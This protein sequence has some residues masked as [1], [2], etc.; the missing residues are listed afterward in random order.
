M[1][2]KEL[3]QE[4]VLRTKLQAEVETEHQ[5]ALKD[6]KA[7][8]NKC[9]E[10][11]EADIKELKK[12]HEKQCEELGREILKQ[13]LEADRLFNELQTNGIQ[14]PRKALFKD[15]DV[16]NS[17]AIGKIINLI[18]TCVIVLLAVGVTR[19]HQANMFTQSGI[20][21]PVM[22]GTVLDDTTN[23][24]TFQSPWWAPDSFKQQG[25][26]IF[27]MDK[28]KKLPATIEWKKEGKM[29]KL[30]I[31]VEGQIA[32]KK[33]AIKTEVLSDRV[34]VWKKNGVAEEDMLS[35]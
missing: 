9:V 34:R 32:L 29:H 17:S 4:K 27:C 19:A 25:F 12:S 21:A 30:A 23:D 6:E 11:H 18:L 31:A 35:W 26:D 10:D 2:Q 22:P 5:Q 14:V 15:D 33:K 8:Y 24:T 1:A 3:D 7:R 16:N 28:T 20:C 13:K